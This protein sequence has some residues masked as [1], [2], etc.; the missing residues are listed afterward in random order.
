MDPRHIRVQSTRTD[1]RGQLRPEYR[2]AD[3]WYRGELL[4]LGV[5]TPDPGPPRSGVLVFDRLA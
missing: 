1:W 5:I 4:R 3:Q 2:E